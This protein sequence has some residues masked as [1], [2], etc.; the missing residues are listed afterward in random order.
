M[1]LKHWVERIAD[2]LKK[3]DIKEHVI[4]SGTSI[5]GAIHIGNS[6]DV[7]IANAITKSL[8]EKGI[9]AKTVWVADDHD[10]LRKVP[11]PL[12]ESFNKYLGVPYSMIPCPKD[13]CEGFVEHFQRP[14]LESLKKFNIE[15]EACSG[16]QM[17]KNGLY[18]KYIRLSLE[19]APEI[20]Q[21]FNKY[22]ENPLPDDWLPYNPICN[23]CGRINTT[24]AKDFQG[25]TVYY[26][27]KCGFSGEMDIKSGLGKLTW[28]VEWAARW[29]ILNVTCE[30]FGKDHAASGGSYLPPPPYLGGT[31]S[32]AASMPS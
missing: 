29:K 7:F 11:Y 30:P 24:Y 3:M 22:R 9:K 8:I 20:R 17:Y 15:L 21:I 2:K 16:A 23:K 18:N 25:D 1:E 5:S 14:F 31:P 4:A 10:P 19:R 27:C 12:P 13:C 26:D 28:R 32:H 6:C